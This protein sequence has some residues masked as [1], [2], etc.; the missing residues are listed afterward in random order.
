M[1]AKDPKMSKW[2]AADTRRHVTLT[3]P[4]KVEIIGQLQSGES[5]SEAMAS[6]NIAL[7]NGMA[8]YDPLRH[9]VYMWRTL[10]SNRHFNSL[11]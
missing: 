2:I 6:Y 8:N 7:E 10:Q 1:A 9:H 11:N 3:T 5:H 4:Q